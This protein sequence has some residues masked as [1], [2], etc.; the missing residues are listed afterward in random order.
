MR[1]EITNFDSGNLNTFVT[2]V[3]KWFLGGLSTD[4]QRKWQK[5]RGSFVL[6]SMGSGKASSK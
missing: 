6:H 2:P 1:D 4:Y 5:S 3:G